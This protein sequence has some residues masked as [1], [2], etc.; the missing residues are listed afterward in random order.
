[1]EEDKKMV[2]PS[3]SARVGYGDEK[4]RYTDTLISSEKSLSKSDMYTS[5]VAGSG[6]EKQ[7]ETYSKVRISTFIAD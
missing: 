1:M 2:G 4:S 7:S 5:P 6:D 3:T